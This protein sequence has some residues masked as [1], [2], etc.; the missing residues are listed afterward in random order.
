MFAHITDYP[1]LHYIQYNI[2]YHKMERCRIS[3]RII[4]HNLRINSGPLTL[5]VNL[6]D[7]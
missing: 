6:K 3:L 5:S 7:F 1:L 2:H 4:L